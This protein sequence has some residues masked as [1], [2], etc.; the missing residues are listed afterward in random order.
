M[1]EVQCFSGRDAYCVGQSEHLR[2][3]FLERKRNDSK[4]DI[5]LRALTHEA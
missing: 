5:W 3:K 2:V 1:I 4:E